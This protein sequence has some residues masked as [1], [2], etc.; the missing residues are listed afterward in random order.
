MRDRR[1]LRVC[2]RE[3]KVAWMKPDTGG[4]YSQGF[5]HNPQGHTDPSNLFIDAIQLDRDCE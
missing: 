2:E 5:K 3:S 1:P 4:A